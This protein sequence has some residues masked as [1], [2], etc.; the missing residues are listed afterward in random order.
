MGDI[1]PQGVASLDSRCLIGRI[2]VAEHY[3]L[4]HTKIIWFQK[5]IFKVSPK[6]SL[7]KLLIHR[8]WPVL[9]TGA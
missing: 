7:L 2:Y 6:I 9:T 5:I 3:M 1:D 4:L 8:M